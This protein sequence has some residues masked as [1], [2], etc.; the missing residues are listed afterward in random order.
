MEKY[1]KYYVI[2]IGLFVWFSQS[3]GLA[4][5]APFK[6]DEIIHDMENVNVCTYVIYQ[7]NVLDRE[8]TNGTALARPVKIIL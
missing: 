8:N 3:I 4:Q 2:G 5:A 6:K 1:M 7:F